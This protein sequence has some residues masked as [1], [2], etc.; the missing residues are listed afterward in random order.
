MVRFQAVASHCGK[1]WR[2]GS[3][4]L[5]NPCGN[6]SRAGAEKAGAEQVNQ[7]SRKI[8]LSVVFRLLP[9]PRSF[10]ASRKGYSYAILVRTR[11]FPQGSWAGALVLPILKGFYASWFVL[12]F[13]E[14]KKMTSEESPKSLPLKKS[15]KKSFC[16]PFHPNILIP[17][18]Y[19]V[20]GR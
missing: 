1:T 3:G 10:E 17:I 5:Q 7:G 8:Q 19:T 9:A 20:P 4:F 16:S 15:Q 18:N 13:Q 11:D 12:R 2:R 6:P 14:A